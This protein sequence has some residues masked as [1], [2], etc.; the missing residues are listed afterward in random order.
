MAAV[1]ITVAISSI[2]VRTSLLHR[3]LASIAVQTLPAEALSIAIDIDRQGAGPTRTRALRQVQTPWLAFMDDDDELL[4]HHLETLC[5]AQCEFGADVV[6]PWFQVIGGYDPIAGNRGKQWNHDEPHTFPIT[7]LVR[8]ELAQQCFF[9]EPLSN[10][11]CSGE[12]FNFWMQ[13]SNLGAKF[14]HVNEITWRW[15]HDSGNTA[16]LPTRW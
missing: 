11:G 3:A 5:N 2:P 8:T 14:H 4:P 16:G 13:M 1:D 7:T 10:V 15:F 6:W 12:D 9:P